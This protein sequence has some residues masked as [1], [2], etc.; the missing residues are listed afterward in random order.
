MT[1]PEGQDHVTKAERIRAILIQYNRRQKVLAAQRLQQQQ[2]PP[3]QQTSSSPIS[4]QVNNG[5]PGN[6]P[7]QGSVPRTA[8]ATSGQMDA[9]PAPDSGNGASQQSRR[10]QVA[11]YQQIL[12]LMEQFRNQLHAL[13]SRKT[14]PNTP[15]NMLT[16][17]ETKEREIRSRLE[18]CHRYAQQLAQRLR[19][20]PGAANA[21]GPPQ[22]GGPQQYQQQPSGQ[23]GQRAQPPQQQAQMTPQQRQS[24]QAQQ[25]MLMQQQQPPQQRIQTPVGSETVETPG[26]IGRGAATRKASQ[27]RTSQR[28][29]SIKGKETDTPEGTTI[30]NVNAAASKPVTMSVSS[31]SM[32]GPSQSGA[33]KTRFPNMLIPEDLKV[34]TPEPVPVQ[35]NNRPSLLGGN[36]TDFSAVTNPVL[37]KPQ[38]FDMEGERVLNKRKLRELVRYVASDEGDAEVTIDGDVEDL[39][40]DLADE[41]VTSVT[42]FACRLAKHRKSDM[43]DMRDVQLNLERNWNIRLP[44]YAADEI[45]STRKF[46][47]NAA[48]HQKINGLSIN[49]SVNKGK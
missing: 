41:F 4:P 17:L 14:D 43:L 21:G 20:Q 13:E 40:L 8:S 35:M 7:A 18:Q 48:H 26:S 37:V 36:A 25:Q 33:M 12:R 27:R 49:K 32:T 28:K 3:S 9:S 38:H 15:A 29:N 47:P 24:L 5:M 34:S 39:M 30:T 19:M 6:W 22:A 16:Q 46:V 42:S 11:K 10:Q 31:P 45:R 23:P 1:T 2:Q 44:G